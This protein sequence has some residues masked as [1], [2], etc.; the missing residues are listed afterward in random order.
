MVW[1]EERPATGARRPTTTL[2]HA[3]EKE[4][5]FLNPAALEIRI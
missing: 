4:R 3:R 1:V 2:D 5:V